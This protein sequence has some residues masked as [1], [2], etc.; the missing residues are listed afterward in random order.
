MR[1]WQELVRQ[2]LAGLELDAAERDEVHAELTTHLEES[3]ETLCKQGLGE[4]EAARR[5]FE[6]VSNW[7]ELQRKISAAKRREHPM[8]K[9]AQQ[10]WIPGLL[11]LVLSML[12]LATLQK[13]GFRLRIVGS[14]SGAV[15]FY[16][17]WLMS[18]P[19]LGAL[20]ARLSSRGGG[21]LS[22]ALLASC[23]PV[24]ALATAFLLMLPIGFVFERI[25][26]NH[27][28][29]NSGLVAT[30]LLRDGIGWLLIPGAALLMGGLL[31][32]VFL[33]RRSSSQ[34]A[35]IGGETTHA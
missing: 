35:G 4:S 13:T 19:F 25:T 17:P 22:T 21:S 1:D 33:N 14:G 16:V 31:A 18:L 2:R 6:Q 8:K 3:Y 30:T 15:F 10:L 32:H 11:T 26:G 29:F 23:F 5:T 7:H 20:G 9:R 34:G 28:Y 12:F 24:L 27:F